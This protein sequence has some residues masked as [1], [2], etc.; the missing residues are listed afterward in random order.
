MHNF[1]LP[2]VSSLIA[3]R[4]SSAASCKLNDKERIL[5]LTT[6]DE[7]TA[8]AVQTKLRVLRMRRVAVVQFPA[9]ATIRRTGSDMNMKERKDW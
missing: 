2:S 5:F 8:A 4:K 6:A 7:H 9:H 3:D 1:T